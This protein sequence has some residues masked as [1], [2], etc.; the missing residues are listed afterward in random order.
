MNFGNLLHWA[1]ICL[2][3]A[4]VAALLGFTGV[5]GTAMEG[6]RILFWVALILLVVSLLFGMLRRG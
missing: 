1:V 3:V 6:A 2:V 4:V 5:A